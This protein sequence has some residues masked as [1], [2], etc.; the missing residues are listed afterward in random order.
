MDMP[1]R[2]VWPEKAVSNPQRDRVCQDLRPRSSSRHVLP[3]HHRAES[4]LANYNRLRCEPFGH[5]DDGHE[6]RGHGDKVDHV[7][8]HQALDER[9][10]LVRVLIVVVIMMAGRFFLV[11][12]TGLRVRTMTMIHRRDLRHPTA[13]THKAAMQ[14]KHL[15]P[16]HRRKGEQGE[17]EVNHGAHQHE[18]TGLRA[19]CPM[20]CAT[21][22]APYGCAS[23]KKTPPS[24]RGTTI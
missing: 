18:T 5:L 4:T 13:V 6:R 14:P 1:C 20:A 2:W 19:D 3:M 12:M 16:Q 10:V 24:G 21:S 8:S 23:L 11:L 17:D 9:R 15:R 7:S 22:L